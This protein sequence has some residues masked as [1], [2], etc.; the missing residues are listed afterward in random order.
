MAFIIEMAGGKSTN[1]HES[2]LDVKV[3]YN[4]NYFNI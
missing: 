2:I 3:K 4:V 1:G